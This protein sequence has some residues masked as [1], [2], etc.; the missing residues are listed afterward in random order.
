MEVVKYPAEVL[1]RAARRIKPGEVDLH[2]LYADMQETMEASHGVGLAAPQVGLG[3]RFI[4]AHSIAEKVT[5]GLAN[6]QIVEFSRETD[7]CSEGCLSFPDM[8][9][10]IERA[11]AIRVRYQDLDFQMHEENYEGHFARVLQH[12]I[13][14]LNGVLIIDRAIDGLFSSEDEEEEA[15][16]QGHEADAAAVGAV[17]DADDD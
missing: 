10:E 6:P 8:Y 11:K 17:P 15:D 12:E 2:A 7:V 4:V 14:H 16:L 9:G 1:S 13:D 5:L 3:I